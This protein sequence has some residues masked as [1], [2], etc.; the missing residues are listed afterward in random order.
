MAGSAT[1]IVPNFTGDPEWSLKRH[2]WQETHLLHIEFAV[3]LLEKT[4]QNQERIARNPVVN[5][6]P[7]H[8]EYRVHSRTFVR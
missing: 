2:I 3:I 7:C 8:A 1:T 5:D 4:A 6:C